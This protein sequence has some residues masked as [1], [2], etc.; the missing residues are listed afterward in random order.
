MESGDQDYRRLFQIFREECEEHIQKLNE[1]L[2]ALERRPQE[3][4]LE[5]ILRSAH[6][7]KGASRMMGFKGM[8]SLAHYLETMLTQLMRGE[9]SL[10]PAIMGVL[11]QDV[12]ALEQGL[13]ALK[14]GEEPPAID[15]LIEQL[16]VAAG[17]KSAA[18]VGPAGREG[19]VE[20][21]EEA[22]ES[23]RPLAGA[24]R[25]PAGRDRAAALATIRVQTDKLD[26][27]I[28]QT[29]ELLV[30]K[31]EASDNLRQLDEA[32]DGLQ[33]WRRRLALEAHAAPALSRVERLSEELHGVL[34]RVAENTHRMELLVDG[35]H[36]GVR[37]LRLLPLSS[38]LEP[39][40]RMVRDLS[41]DLGKE[42]ELRL[43][44]T[45]TRLDKKILEELRE[46]L[47]HLVRN[48]IDHGMETPDE[49]ENKG[50]ARQGTIRIA[51]RQEGPKV[52]ITIEDDGRGLDRRA[53]ESSAVK[54]G[55]ASAEDVARWRDEEI[56]DLIFRP[57][58][59]TSAQV[60]E[61][62]GRGIGLDAV[63]EKLERLKGSIF[64]ESTPGKGATFTLSLPLTLSTTHALL[65]EAGGD[66]FCIPTDA[67][68]K[69]LLIPHD[70]IMPI[71][72]KTTVVVD[73]APLAFAWLADVLELPRKERSNGAFPALLLKSPRGS[74]LFGV[75]AF[76][77][78]E[79]I[80]V[81]ALGRFFGHVPHVSGG[82]VLGK[83]EIA[84]ILNPYDL[85]RSLS[86]QARPEIA[87][88]AR[89]AVALPGAKKK[90]LVAEDSLT[91]RT[92]EKNILEAAGFEVTTAVDGE[93]ALIRLYEKPF[94][95]VVSD[96]QM[97]RLDG[98]ALTE[99]IKR[100]QR[101]K[102]LPVILVTAL[103]TE[104]DKRRGNEAGADAYIT[105]ASFDEKRFLEII[106]RF[107]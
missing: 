63:L 2:L 62:S 25:A 75:E 82:T 36:E 72:G 10:T 19:K 93:E 96:V 29:G 28:N 27:L 54:K 92:M 35:V 18:E 106:R 12:D 57:G 73:G 102:D 48:S 65:F 15:S 64:T 98:I 101:F 34:S 86:H 5:E 14:E 95:I 70:T 45:S 44:G 32:L 40:P 107:V 50:K 21:V 81:K 58:F 38:I 71:E 90:V 17:E 43:E 49:R 77:G 47:I 76:R 26:D 105:K 41:R 59:S 69:T 97:P 31:I 8:E 88:P 104:A 9:K 83:G 3:A 89:P 23:P 53:I 55:L 91:T 4:P 22:G 100:D 84:L 67:L 11:Y 79:E 1:G 99:R 20:K 68:E 87:T 13:S 94:D 33:E 103:Q 39:F 60:T 30:T 51:A 7:L 24:G 80:V 37:D 42:A 56:W 66:V 74:A 61:V 6:S 52:V 46:P 85:L 16:Q 78:E